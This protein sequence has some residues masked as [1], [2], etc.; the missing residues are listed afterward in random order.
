MAE[1]Y[2][3]TT[4]MPLYEDTRRVIL[5]LE[6]ELSSKWQ[7]MYR[8]LS[9]TMWQPEYKGIWVDPDS[10]IPK[11]LPEYDQSLAYRL[12]REAGVR[13]HMAD[14]SVSLAQL[15]QLVDLEAERITLTEAGK[16]F[17]QCDEST[18]ATLDQYEGILYILRDVAERGPCG[19]S[20][21]LESFRVFLNRYTAF[22]TSKSGFQVLRTRLSNLK[23]R[24][25]I[26]R[27]GKNYQ[28]T[29]AGIVYLARWPAA[30]ENDS[31]TVH[32]YSHYSQIIKLNNQNDAA[33]S[34]HLSEHLRNMD[35]YQFERLVKYLLEVMGY[36]N[37]EV[38]G[39]SNDKGVD[40]V[41]NIELGI[42]RVRE[43]IQVKR[44]QANVGR[45]VLDSLRG[46]LHRFD[47]V[48]ATVVTTSG[49]SAGAKEAAFEK[50]AAP[51]TLI[52]G[53]RLIDLLIQ[54]NIGIRKSEIRVLEFDAESLREF[55]SE[56]KSEAVL[57]EEPKK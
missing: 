42:S 40:V 13:P 54:H 45:P 12:W 11:V 3:I 36:E 41:A 20:L 23:H 51:I 18:V 43:V 14:T 15:H 38:T 28:I 6:G 56:E 25:L 22:S 1:K 46:S 27:R 9:S 39:G 7:S 24:G 16:L 19:E 29:D 37:V 33:T 17:L 57:L 34:Q 53:K 35:P 31:D 10:Y 30:A 55:S 32:D 44:Q 48:R 52:D 4:W 5:V 50:G 26:E 2:S 8:A 47:A 21:L 49:F